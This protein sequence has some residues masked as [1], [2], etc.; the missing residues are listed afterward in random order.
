MIIIGALI[1]RISSLVLLEFQYR[2]KLYSQS[3]EGMSMWSRE[4]QPFFHYMGGP[5]PDS[6]PFAT[7]GWLDPGVGALVGAAAFLGG[8]SRISL[9]T[10][11]MMVEITGDPVMI[12]PV[13]VATLVAVVVGNVWNHGLYHSLIDVASFPF[14]PSKWPKGIQRSLRVEHVLQTEGVKVASV[15]LTAQRTELRATL[16]GHTY[17]GF[18]V[19][20]F[21]GVV[22][23]L[24]TRSNLEKMLSELTDTVD[25]G[26]TTDFHHVTIQASLPLEVAFNLFKQMELAHITVVDSSYRPKAILTR[27]SLLPWVVQGRMGHRTVRPTIQ[28]P[29]NFRT[30]SEDM[31]LATFGLNAS[32]D[33]L[34]GGHFG[35]VMTMQLGHDCEVATISS[36]G[37]SRQVSGPET[38]PGA[39]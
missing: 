21:N 3:G 39:E 10:T 8:C 22:V 27:G 16:D 7:D 38:S 34:E 18:P 37:A 24:A 32:G 20:G 35:G 2:L 19:V 11:V 6:V 29:R 30:G 28:R 4:W 25:V 26:R 15:P 14:L 33:G 9:M 36:G 5:L 23:G 1:G 31:T 12:A 17:S 13:G